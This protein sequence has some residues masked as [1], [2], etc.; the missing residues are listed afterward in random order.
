MAKC[1]SWLVSSLFTEKHS[2]NE[3]SSKI[4]AFIQSPDLSCW[5]QK[6]VVV[7]M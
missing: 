3:G 4:R 1:N 5:V 6:K 2:L 7:L